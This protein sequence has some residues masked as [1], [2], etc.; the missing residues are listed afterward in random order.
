MKKFSLI[1]VTI[2]MVYGCSI[3]IPEK[4]TTLSTD[5]DPIPTVDPAEDSQSPSSQESLKDKW[6]FSAREY[7]FKDAL[8]SAPTGWHVPSRLELLEAFDK[9]E[10]T[11]AEED[12]LMVWS[13]TE[14]IYDKEN[15][16]WMVNMSDGLS[17]RENKQNEFRVL[18]IKDSTTS[19]SGTTVN[20]NNSSSSTGT[21][22][23]GVTI[24][25]NNNN[26]NNCSVPSTQGESLTKQA[27]QQSDDDD[28]TDEY[29]SDEEAK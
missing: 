10:F 3:K 11:W 12:N 13:S 20:Q 14:L 19:S 15:V 1:L 29:F 6:R 28:Y 25:N 26:N 2:L 8:A 24:I 17:L 21:D 27:T 4:D 18:Y 22:G 9:S 23:N 7:T 5:N 16:A